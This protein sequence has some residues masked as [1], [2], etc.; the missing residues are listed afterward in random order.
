M[1]LAFNNY[2]CETNQDSDIKSQ[3]IKNDDCFTKTKDMFSEYVCT[4]L[5]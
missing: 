5:E 4:I 3:T 2:S 1:F